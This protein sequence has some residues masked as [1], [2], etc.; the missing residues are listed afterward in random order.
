MDPV[1]RGIPFCPPTFFI[2]RLVYSGSK[3]HPWRTLD[4]SNTPGV[5]EGYRTPV[6]LD[7]LFN[8]S[9]TEIHIIQ[10]PRKNEEDFRLI[11]IHWYAEIR[12]TVNRD[13]Q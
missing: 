2:L 3:V 7:P 9:R 5:L 8:L 13:C 12:G 6:L 10:G 1:G 11:N 4:R